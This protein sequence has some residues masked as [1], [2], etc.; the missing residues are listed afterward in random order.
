[1]EEAEL[2]SSSTEDC[3]SELGLVFAAQG[4]FEVGSSSQMALAVE[5][6]RLGQIG[7]P[8][9]STEQTGVHGDSQ[10]VSGG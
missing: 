9:V 5:S 4:P 10:C 2:G 3:E 7:R 6:G 8:R 1:M